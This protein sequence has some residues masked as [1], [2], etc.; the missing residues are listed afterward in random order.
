M[1]VEID[2]DAVNEMRNVADAELWLRD[3]ARF[4]A[5]RGGAGN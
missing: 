5:R 4:G 3:V 2:D 1:Q